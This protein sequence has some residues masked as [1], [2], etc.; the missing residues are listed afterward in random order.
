MS[1]RLHGRRLALPLVPWMRLRFRSQTS[2]IEGAKIVLE[3]E[4]TPAR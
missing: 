1:Y 4:K 2:R 3:A